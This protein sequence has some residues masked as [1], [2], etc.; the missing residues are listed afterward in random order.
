MKLP[1]TRPN[2]PSSQP[3]PI[4]VHLLSRLTFIGVAG[5]CRFIGWQVGEP[6]PT[7]IGR[8]VTVHPAHQVVNP[9]L[10]TATSVRGFVQQLPLMPSTWVITYTL[11]HRACSGVPEYTEFLLLLLLSII[12]ST[13]LCSANKY[14]CIWLYHQQI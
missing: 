1:N 11:C 10:S 7:I 9:S 14:Y 5:L 13:H 12:P 6:R 4:P 8:Y 3:S 2:D